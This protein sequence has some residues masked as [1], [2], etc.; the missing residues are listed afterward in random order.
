ML[1]DQLAG[2]MGDSDQI[3]FPPPDCKRYWLTK[4]EKVD[5]TSKVNLR[6]VNYMGT[7][8]V[9]DI[10]PL[11]NF[12]IAMTKIWGTITRFIFSTLYKHSWL[13]KIEKADGT[14]EFNLENSWIEKCPSL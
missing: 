14:Y 3:C 11:L 5:C 12:I 1:T 8:L 10:K 2:L 6:N 13:T 7:A 4:I 9:D